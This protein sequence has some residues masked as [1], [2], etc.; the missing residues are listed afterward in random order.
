MKT[1]ELAN[2]CLE[3]LSFVSRVNHYSAT[4]F[5]WQAEHDMAIATFTT[6]CRDLR[7]SENDPAIRGDKYDEYVAQMD[8]A[9]IDATNEHYPMGENGVRIDRDA[10][11]PA[12][13]K[14]KVVADND[15]PQEG[16]STE[17]DGG[18]VSVINGLEPEQP[19]EPIAAAG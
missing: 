6:A 14:P 2:E 10:E 13:F 7:T 16:T 3:A 18:T 4:F 15:I 8:R 1:N 17:D 9:I 5:L 12:V 11:K 19:E